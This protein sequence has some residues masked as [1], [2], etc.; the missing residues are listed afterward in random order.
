MTPEL[1]L[2]YAVKRWGG[3]AALVAT[4]AVG[5]FA[6]DRA[7]NHVANQVGEAMATLATA[8]SF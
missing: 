3:V 7:V 5:W 8:I 6:A 4:L 1:K 2:F